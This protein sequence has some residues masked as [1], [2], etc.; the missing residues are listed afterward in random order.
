[1]PGLTYK[2]ENIMTSFWYL[3]EKE[4]PDPAKAAFSSIEGVFS[5]KGEHIAKD[6]VS[7][8]IKVKV[9]D[10]YY[11]IKK[12][13]YGGKWMRRYFGRSR[14]RAEWKNIQYFKEM[15]IPTPDLIAY[16]EEKKWGIFQ[17][18]AIITKEIR[19]TIDMANLAKKRASIMNDKIW[20]RHVASLLATYTRKIHTSGFVHKDLK[21]RNILVSSEQKP[22]I[23]FIDCP[24]GRKKNALVRKRWII[25][26]LACLDK[27]A[28][29]ILSR[30][31]R[32]WF[33]KQYSNHNK[34][35]A[36]DKNMIKKVTVF[37]E[38]RE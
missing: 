11:Y 3:E 25:K 21:W 26:D 29:H 2:T 5:L 8:V 28:K 33:Y 37:F 23:Y 17:R 20:F 38:G 14:V 13:Y 35:T 34:L 22:D 7:T 15:N 36:H 27:M 19:D 4:T 31:Q 10:H 12:Y 9:G 18:G 24:C 6:P 1:M 32:L 16:G 30:T